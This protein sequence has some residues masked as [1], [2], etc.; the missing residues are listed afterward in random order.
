[1]VKN[2]LEPRRVVSFVALIFSFLGLVI[3]IILSSWTFYQSSK[4]K[5]RNLNFSPDEH[6]RFEKTIAAL[7]TQLKDMENWRKMVDKARNASFSSEEEPSLSRLKRSV[8]EIVTHEY[9]SSGTTYTHWGSNSCPNSGAQLLYNG[10]VAAGYYG[11][12]GGGADYQCLPH[13]PQYGY[14]NPGTQ[15][16]TKLGGS[17]MYGTEYRG[18]SIY[19]FKND[20]NDG[21]SLNQMDSVCAVCY[22]PVRSITLMIPAWQECP[23]GWTFEY[24]GYLMASHYK[25]HRSNFVCVNDTPES[26]ESGENTSGGSYLYPVE[27][28]CGAIPCPHYSNGLELTCVVCTK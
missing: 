18:D 14:K 27:G 1:M 7:R 19:P 3:V 11:H 6:E 21:K 16:T 13:K 10:V 8:K 4:E 25:Q 26:K 15:Y 28:I 2:D 23:T 22:V 20:K 17:S 24:K 12:T 5:V 9:K